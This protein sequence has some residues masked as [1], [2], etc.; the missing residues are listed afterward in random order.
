M[1]RTSA[2][3]KPAPQRSARKR[4]RKHIPNVAL[5]V[6]T[7]RSY[8]RNVLRGIGDYARI[9]GPWL[10]H[11]P[12]DVPVRGLPSQD[13]WRGDG[14]IA[15]PRQNQAFLAELVKCGVPVVSLSGPPGSAGLPAVRAN[16]GIVAQLAMA[17]FRDRGFIRFAYCGTPS[18][19]D[20][21]PTGRNFQAL[22]QQAGHSCE[23]YHPPSDFGSHTMRLENLS[24]WLRSLRTPVG[25]LASNDQRAREVLDACRLVGK[26]VPEEVAVLGVNDDELICEMANPPLSSVIHNARRIGYEAAAMLHRLMQGKQV[27]ADIEVDPLGVTARQSTDLLAIE[28]PEVANAVRF[29]REHACDCIRVDDVLDQVA[30]SRRALEKRFRTAVGRPPHVEIRRVQLERVKQLLVGSDYK[31][32]KIAE[33]TGF[34]TAQYLAGL[35]H[36]V[37][38]VTPGAWRQAGRSGAK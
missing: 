21:P 26:H 17:H 19:W 28:D 16:Q 30:L 38:G 32:E 23:I 8:G 10:F 5:L 11:L 37:V 3:D 35:F 9:Y 18:E 15:Q 22:A 34:S 4:A 12:N 31:L 7:T 24:K 20:W 14:I 27:V 33:L 29:I 6:E 13:E 36:R 25:L 2:E 1:Q